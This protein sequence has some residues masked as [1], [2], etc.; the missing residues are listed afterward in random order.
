MNTDQSGLQLELYSNRTLNFQGEKT[1]LAAVHSV[2]NTT[3]SYTM[4]PMI[5]MIGHLVGPLFLCLKEPSGRLT[6][7]VKKTL[8]QAK[9]IILTC[10]K[11]GKLST[12]RLQYRRDN[13]LEPAIETNKFLLIPDSW[14]AQS[15]K[16]LY[17]KLKN[18]QR[19]EIPKRTTSW[20]QPLD[21][22]FSRQFKAIVRKVYDHI[23][24]DNIDINISQRNNIKLN[25]VIHNQLS[26]KRLVPMIKYAWYK[27][28][29]IKDNPGAFQNVKQICF[30]FTDISCVQ[31]GHNDTCFITCGWCQKTFCF[32]HFFEVY[33]MH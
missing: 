3:H 4:Q 18:C 30:S 9:N 8:F 1:T 7:N 28:G 2:H 16:T 14:D 23:R 5:S 13:V 12:S 17:E 25:S 31:K 10:S 32:H 26:S 21:V 6:K 11:S 27:S 24:L 19:I 33:H 29:Y 20:I 22:Y 15:N